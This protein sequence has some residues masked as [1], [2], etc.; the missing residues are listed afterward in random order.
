MSKPL[1]LHGF[2]GSGGASLNFKLVAYATEEALLATTPSEGTIG[3]ITENEIT[4]WL[5]SPVQPASLLDGAVWISTGTS[6]PVPFNALKSAKQA[7]YIYP[8]AAK[9]YISGA[10]VDLTAKSY[11]G[12]EWVDWACE[13]VLIPGLGVFDSK[14]T[15]G[16]FKSCTENDD[17][18]YTI[19]LQNTAFCGVLVDVTEYTTMTIEGS[20]T[21]AAVAA[22]YGLFSQTANAYSAQIAG[23]N[24]SGASEVNNSYDITNITG[25]VYFG[26][27]TKLG[28]ENLQTC[29]FTL[30]KVVF[31]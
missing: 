8:I 25:E 1:H 31:S 14:E 9:Q 10:W 27:A 6:S 13:Y 28:S 15:S 2:G 21:S 5:L 3:V 4:A 7:V 12:G 17:G 18:T 22:Y 11:Q 29:T 24:A 30:T 16:V 26:V 19:V 23:C 20:N